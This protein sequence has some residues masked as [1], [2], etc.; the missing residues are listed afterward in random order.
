MT[1]QSIITGRR[2]T[3]KK[4]TRNNIRKSLKKYQKA[5]T[6]SVD[7]IIAKGALVLSND[8]YKKSIHKLSKPAFIRKSY[9][10]RTMNR[11]K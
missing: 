2:S 8:S 3:L 5:G 1:N 4:I 11:K 7:D 6:V 9:R 10:R